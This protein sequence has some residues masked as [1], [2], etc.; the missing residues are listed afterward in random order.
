VRNYSITVVPITVIIEERAYRNGVDLTPQEFYQILRKTKSVP[1]TS[2][3][4][5]GAFL[6]TYRDLAKQADGIVSIHVSYKL[7]GIFSSATHAAHMLPDTPIQVIDSG[8]A[9]SAMGFIVREAARAAA[10]GKSLGEVVQ[11]AQAMIPRVKVVAM[12][13][14]LQYLKR[15]GRVP[16]VTAMASS[17]LNIKPILSLGGGEVRLL[18]KTRTRARA[19]AKMIALMQEMVSSYES[20]HVAVMEADAR[21]QAELLAQE[22]ERKFNCAELHIAEFTPVMGAHSGPGVLGL[23]FYGE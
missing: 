12:L 7:S 13:D 8:T 22:V 17:L 21:P 2:H 6:Q 14:T 20:V 3:P 15:S 11:V 5:V 18:A 23:A 16:A 19:M 1:T 10:A 4:T 9:T